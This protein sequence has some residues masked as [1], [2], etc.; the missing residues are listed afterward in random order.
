MIRRWPPEKRVWP[1]T[2]D[3]V[4]GPP[5]SRSASALSARQEECLVWAARGKTYLEIAAILGLTFGS[6]KTHLDAARHKLRCS[7]LAHATAVAV[8]TRKIS[9]ASIVSPSEVVE[10][11]LIRQKGSVK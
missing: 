7:T 6:V 11:N 2:T 4:D 1:M 3:I 8:A 9:A 5:E 10:D